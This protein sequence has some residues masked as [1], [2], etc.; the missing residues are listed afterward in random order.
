MNRKAEGAV[1]SYSATFTTAGTTTIG[2]FDSTH[3]PGSGIASNDTLIIHVRFYS[4]QENM[5]CSLLTP[6]G[7][8]AYDL[9]VN[10]TSGVNGTTRRISSAWIKRADGINDL[11]DIDVLTA[12][13]SGPSPTSEVQFSATMSAYDAKTTVEAFQS[14]AAPL[15]TSQT[16]NAGTVSAP[17]RS[18]VVFWGYNAYIVATIPPVVTA[19]GFTSQFTNDDAGNFRTG[20]I[21]ILDQQFTTADASVDLCRL[22]VTQGNSAG[23]HVAGYIVLKEVTTGALVR[24]RRIGDGN[25]IYR[26]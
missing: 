18:V 12:V 4:E 9:P 2:S 17:A 26:F 5:S 21:R 20:P 6:S 10:T 25:G 19:N 11:P 23:E 22:E 24:G 1:A 15:G 8:T 14:V 16:T 7:W 13:G 3:E